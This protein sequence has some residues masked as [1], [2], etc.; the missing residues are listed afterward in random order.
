[1]VYQIPLA[2]QTTTQPAQAEAQNF[3]LRLFRGTATSV[4]KLQQLF[5]N[6]S[7]EA[8]ENQIAYIS[9]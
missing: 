3:L 2:T 7:A 4:R 6:F 5:T 9:Q 8:P 1:M